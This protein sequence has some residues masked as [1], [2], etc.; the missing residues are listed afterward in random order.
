M[1]CAL[2]TLSRKHNPKHT[3]YKTEGWMGSRLNLEV[4]EARQIVNRIPVENPKPV[5]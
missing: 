4:G 1:L 3:A 5:T 2:S